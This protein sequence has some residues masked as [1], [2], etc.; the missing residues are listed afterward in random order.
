ITTDHIGA[1]TF[2]SRPQIR[3]LHQRGHGIGSHSCSHPERMSSCGWDHLVLEWQQ[4]RAAL[5]DIL[6]EPVTTASVPGGFY[7][8]AVARAAAHAGVK[9]L[10]NSEPTRRVFP[11][12][13]CLIVGRYSVV[14]GMGPDAAA[15]LALGK[16]FPRL[17]QS[18]SWKLKKL[19]KATGGRVY[20]RL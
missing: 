20:L 9:V 11:I 14:R 13:G 15:A 17:R 3:D 1:P 16:F 5:E 2:L 18:T 10:F 12:E 8:R 19:A 6:G 7:S 4:S